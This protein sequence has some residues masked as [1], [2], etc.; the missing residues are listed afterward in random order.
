MRQHYRIGSKPEYSG[1]LFK[2]R[3]AD[4]EIINHNNDLTLLVQRNAYAALNEKTAAPSLRRQFLLF[5]YSAIAST[6]HDETQTPQSMQVSALISYTVSPC[7][8]ASTG[9]SPTQA[10]QDTHSALIL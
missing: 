5:Y 7:D 1:L 8:I 4:P 3:P 10:P 2:T 6:G 9:H